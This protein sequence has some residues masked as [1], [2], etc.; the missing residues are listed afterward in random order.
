[1][2]KFYNCKYSMDPI[3]LKS[4]LKYGHIFSVCL[5]GKINIKLLMVV[6]LGLLLYEGRECYY[7]YF[8]YFCIVREVTMSHKSEDQYNF[9]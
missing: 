9:C 4:K 7:F 6:T 1:M 2:S 8:S 3:L 5:Y